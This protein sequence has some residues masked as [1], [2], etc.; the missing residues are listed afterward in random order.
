MAERVPCHAEGKMVSLR[1]ENACA[2]GKRKVLGVGIR[3]NYSNYVLLLPRCIG[4]PQS[5]FPTF[6]MPIWC[7]MGEFLD[8]RGVLDGIIDRGRRNLA[9]FLPPPMISP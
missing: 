7:H 6:Q 3:P 4:D 2:H 8:N 1:G 5:R 9:L